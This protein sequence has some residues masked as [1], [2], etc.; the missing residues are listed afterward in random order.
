MNESMVLQKSSSDLWPAKRNLLGLGV[1]CVEYDQAV[2]CVIQAATDRQ[3]AIVSCHAVHA[4]TTISRDKAL[5]E[6]AN[7]F[8]MIT[9][10]GQPVRWSL[11]LLHRAGLKERVYGP[12]L[13]WRVLHQSAQRQLPIY[14]YG[15]SPESLQQLIDR[16]TAQIPGLIIAG[17]QSPPY[18]E[19]SDQEME[20]VADQINASG[21]T[22]V[23]IGLGCPKQDRFAAA[24]ADR[25]NAVQIC[26]GAAFDF[27]AGCKS[28]AP[29]WMQRVGLE[30]LFRLGCEPRRLWRRYLVTNTQFVL[31]VAGAL[32][33]RRDE[34]AG[35]N[36]TSISS[37]ASS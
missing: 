18:R 37:R 36:P 2:D 22:I 7:R 17:S 29:A 5:C 20:T 32:F 25:I 23:F 30:W 8:A 33:S 13:M 28:T 35:P 15:G 26:V 19:L 3:R 31:G 1:S 12:E 27:H 14:L 11:N 24:Q 6:A 16:L 34:M 10:D 4:V 9:P 21:A